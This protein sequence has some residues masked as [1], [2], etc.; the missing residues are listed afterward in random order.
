MVPANEL[1]DA[2]DHTTKPTRLPGHGL[3]T[4]RQS[5]WSRGAKE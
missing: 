1:A 4:A 2:S 3:V 5:G